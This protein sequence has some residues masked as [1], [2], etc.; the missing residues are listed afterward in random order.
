MAAEAVRLFE[1][2]A[3]ERNREGGKTAGR[4]RP[5]ARDDSTLAYEDE[6]KRSVSQA[7]KAANAGVSATM[8][9]R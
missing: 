6:S 5:K 3:R 4:G 1:E 9:T 2:E 7:A 8:G